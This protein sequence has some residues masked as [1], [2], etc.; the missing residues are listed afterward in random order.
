MV[1]II[2]TKILMGDY[3]SSN[4]IFDTTFQNDQ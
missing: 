2:K 3:Q 1:L 4:E